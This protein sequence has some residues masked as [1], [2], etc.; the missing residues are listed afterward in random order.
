VSAS[1]GRNKIM[2]RNPIIYLCIVTI[3]ATVV[4]MIEK[5]NKPRHGTAET[6][7]LFA[8]LD[9][10]KVTRIEIEHLIN[11]IELKRHFY[12]WT[13]EEFKTAMGKKLEGGEVKAASKPAQEKIVADNAKVR[14][15]IDTLK[16]TRVETIISSNP[17]KQA[18]LQVNNIGLQ[19]RAYDSSGN[20]LAHLYI[21]KNGPDYMTTYVRKEGDDN[22]YL[23]KQYL[24]PLFTPQIDSWRYRSNWEKLAESRKSVAASK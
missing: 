13:I 3:V 22:V 15:L 1:G 19:V 17:E 2:K 5:P 21:G 6:A 10:A 8:E 18:Q 11:G 14:R 9:P 16:N 12:N 24:G 23:V 4:W 7:R 20:L